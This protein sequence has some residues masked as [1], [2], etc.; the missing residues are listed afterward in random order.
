MTRRQDR[1]PGALRRCLATG[2]Q[3]WPFDGSHCRRLDKWS[4]HPKKCAE[5][6][7]GIAKMPFKL[8]LKK[9]QQKYN[10]STKS[11]FV[12]TVELLDNSL[13]E[14]T[15]TADSTGKKWNAKAITPMPNSEQ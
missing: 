3:S 5:P 8:K 12:I 10:V 13:L 2:R 4:P 6:A 15:L 1:E 7:A 9:S 11:M 14:C